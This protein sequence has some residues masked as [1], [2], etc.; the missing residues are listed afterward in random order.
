MIKQSRS[1]TSSSK[2]TAKITGMKI[3]KLFIV[4]AP[5]LSMNLVVDPLAARQ[6][7]HYLALLKI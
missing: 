7:Y 2:E 3:L 4:L 6:R 1:K 5:G